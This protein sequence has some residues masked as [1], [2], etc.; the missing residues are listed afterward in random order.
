M[1]RQIRARVEA[2]VEELTLLVRKA[3][4][5]AVSEA[6]GGRAGQPKPKPAL[7]GAPKARGRG[8][9]RSSSELEK[10][11]GAISSFVAEHPGSGATQ[12]ARELGVHTKELV[13][14]IRKLMSEGVLG[15]KG[16]KRAT[17]YFRSKK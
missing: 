1:D 11:S 13:L 17:K 3:A 9:K 14:P 4:L 6:L 8:A 7:R 15:S 12:I 10:L 16:Q 5:E 2:F